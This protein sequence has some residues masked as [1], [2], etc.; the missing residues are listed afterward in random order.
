MSFL[1]YKKTPSQQWTPKRSIYTLPLKMEQVDNF[2]CEKD[3]KSCL[4]VPKIDL[5]I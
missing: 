4:I 5:L 3:S 1:H 2:P